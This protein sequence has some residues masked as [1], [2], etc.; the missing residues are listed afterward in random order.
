M[1]IKSFKD[2]LISKEGIEFL[3]SYKRLESIISEKE[4]NKK[5]EKTFSKD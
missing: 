1:K 2:F 4:I 5:I 3:K